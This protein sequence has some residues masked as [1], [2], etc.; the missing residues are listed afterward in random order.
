MAVGDITTGLVAR[1]R[2]YLDEASAGF[3]TQDEIYKA[4][5][6]G[7]RE[8]IT[9]VLAVYKQKLS[10]NPDEKLPEVLRNCFTTTTG[11]GSAALPA[12]FLF[13]LSVYTATVP[14]YTRPDGMQR[15][16]SKLNTYLAS[17]AAQPFCSFSAT[18]IVFET[19]VSWTMEYLQTPTSDIDATH[20][21]SLGAISYNAIVE[22]A[23]AFLLNKDE[24]PRAQQ[25][26][27]KF[28]NEM[29]NLSF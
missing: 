18:Q 25:H 19:S 3:W 15:G 6:D 17:S 1:V 29:Q 23:A 28:F 24:N 26:L 5:T 7:Q 4:L 12:G 9:F 21:P 8:V 20:D 13:P 2:T 27:S 11:I 22:Y 10:V 16:A 14:V